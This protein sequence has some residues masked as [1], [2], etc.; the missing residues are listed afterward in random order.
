MKSE[1]P[2]RATNPPRAP[3]RASYTRATALAPA[4]AGHA[5]IGD[6]EARSLRGRAL[7]QC[8]SCGE[9]AGA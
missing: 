7:R 3:P 4:A 2:R 1:E 5:P 6:D 8:G 9:A